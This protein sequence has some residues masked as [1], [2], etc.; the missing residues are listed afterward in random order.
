MYRYSFGAGRVRLF[1]E[2]D[3][4]GWWW[5]RQIEQHLVLSIKAAIATVHESRFRAA[6]NV[7]FVHAES[8]NWVVMACQGPCLLPP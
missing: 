3:L 4:H 2:C 6:S 5:P 8:A 1:K 7:V